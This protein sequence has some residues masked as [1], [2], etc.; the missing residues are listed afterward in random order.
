MLYGST[1][2]VNVLVFT[3]ILVLILFGNLTCHRLGRIR[4]EL[5]FALLVLSIAVAYLTPTA[6][7]LAIDAPVLRVLAAV[8][9]YLGLRVPL[10]DPWVQVPARGGPA[11]LLGGLRAGRPGPVPAGALNTPAGL[12]VTPDGHLV[13]ANGTCPTTVILPGNPL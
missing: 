10:A 2:S 3:G 4:L 9:S 7:L 12:A 5:W 11:V 1:W 6:S 8:G 13:I